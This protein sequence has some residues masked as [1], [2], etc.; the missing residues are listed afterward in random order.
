MKGEQDDTNRLLFWVYVE[1][2][3]DLMTGQAHVFKQ[4][5]VLVGPLRPL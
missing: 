4:N 1:T 2:R 3:E 5:C